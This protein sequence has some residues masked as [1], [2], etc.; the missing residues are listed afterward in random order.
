MKPS[1]QYRVIIYSIYS[2]IK[3]IKMNILK[4]LIYSGLCFS[5]FLSFTSCQD[6]GT[7]TKD[8][9]VKVAAKD[10][11]NT[12]SVKFVSKP[13]KKF[14][15]VNVKPNQRLASPFNVELNSKGLWSA[16]EGEV[17]MVTVVDSDGNK[18]GSA[19]LSSTDGNWMTSGPAKFGSKLNFQL[20]SSKSGKLVFS[21]NAGPGDGAEAGKIELFEIPVIFE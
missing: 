11:K 8:K 1:L 4:S 13:F 5:L 7:S 18:L 14:P 21:S 10:K 9:H 15:K 2:F 20:K 12:K 16:S 3:K 6:S 17:G 19:I